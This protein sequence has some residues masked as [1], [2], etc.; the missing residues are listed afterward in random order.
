MKNFKRSRDNVNDCPAYS[1]LVIC[2]TCKQEYEC[3]TIDMDKLNNPID[4]F[5]C[6]MAKGNVK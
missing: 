5:M 6:Y 3:K 1:A 4:C 2:P